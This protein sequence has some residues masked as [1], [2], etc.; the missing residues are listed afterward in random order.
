M[1]RGTMSG[2]DHPCSTQSWSTGE[3]VRLETANFILR[4]LEPEDASDRFMSWIGNTALMERLGTKARPSRDRARRYIGRMDNATN[5]IL[6]VFPRG[7]DA[8]VGWIRITHASAHRRAGLSILIGEKLHRG[9][10]NTAE[11]QR[12]VHDFLFQT[13]GVHKAVAIVHGN[14]IHG[15]RLAERCGYR[16][17]VLL[18]DH[19]R[20]A[21]GAWRDIAHYGLLEPEWR[22]ARESADTP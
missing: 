3:K 7:A 14:D 17:E 5:F 13:L 2:T 1:S 19:E 4:S 6:G 12:A 16:L 21:D 10:K 18:R 15:R 11:L 8:L 9:R 22:A 20:T